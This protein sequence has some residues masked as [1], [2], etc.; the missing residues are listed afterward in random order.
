MSG[1]LIFATI[2]ISL[3]LIFY[4]IG[5][6]SE[7][8]AKVLRKWHVIVL[9]MGLSFDVIG[10]FSMV[11]IARSGASNTD[12]VESMIHGISGAA[13]ILL[14]AFHVMWATFVLSKRDGEKN[15]IFHKFS[16]IVWILWLI[17]YFIGMAIGMR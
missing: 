5:V 4:T 15:L 10:T 1:I 8:K 17:P 14:I 7:R 11:M 3:A 12:A 6:W 2:T 13:A 9:W 16:L